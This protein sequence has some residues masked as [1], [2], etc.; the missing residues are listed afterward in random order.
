MVARIKLFFRV[1]NPLNST[2]ADKSQLWKNMNRNKIA[3]IA[4]TKKPTTIRIPLSRLLTQNAFAYTT[5]TVIK[6]SRIPQRKDDLKFFPNAFQKSFQTNTDFLS[7]ISLVTLSNAVTAG[8]NVTIGIHAMVNTTFRRSKRQKLRKYN[9]KNKKKRFF[10]GSFLLMPLPGL[11][12]SKKSK[13]PATFTH[14]F[15]ALL[16]VICHRFS[17]PSSPTPYQK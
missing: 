17:C 7:T 5:A 1:A 2:F 3:K 8:P 14:P 13:I 10:N 12:G 9:S 6:I 16:Y 11:D 15:F 4:V